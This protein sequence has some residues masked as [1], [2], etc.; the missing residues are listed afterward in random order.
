MVGEGEF[1]MVSCLEE[2]RELERTSIISVHHLGECRASI[3]SQ[4]RQALQNCSSRW[5]SYLAVHLNVYLQKPDL[6]RKFE[7]IE[8]RW[9]LSLTLPSER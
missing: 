5:Q 7:G 3:S 1:N 2:C 6:P 8:E 9:L 4:F